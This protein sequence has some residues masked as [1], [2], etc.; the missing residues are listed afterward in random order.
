MHIQIIAVG[1]KMPNWVDTGIKAFLRRFNQD[2]T[3]SLKEVPAS[4]RA[5]TANVATIVE[6]E[7]KRCLASVDKGNRLIALEVNGKTWSTADLKDRLNEWKMDGRNVSLLI[8]GPDGLSSECR[9][10][11][12]QHW[13]LSALTLPHPMVRLI[14]T[15]AIYRAWSLSNNHPYH[16]E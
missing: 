6:E 14:V 1:N 8:G 13:S 16:R 9:S 2:L 15:E 10:A 12:E 4:K 5:K 3:L 11:A 7:G